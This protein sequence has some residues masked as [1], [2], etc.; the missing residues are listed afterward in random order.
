MALDVSDG[1]TSFYEFLGQLPLFVRPSP[2]CIAVSIF[3]L[4][5]ATGY[6]SGFQ[7]SI[8]SAKRSFTCNAMFALFG[9]SRTAVKVNSMTP[10][11]I[12]ITFEVENR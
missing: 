1:N 3:L 6:S 4:L 10:N 7:I 5:R 2:P 8:H 11:D 9:V 12:F